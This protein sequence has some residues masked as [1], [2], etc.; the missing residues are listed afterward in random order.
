MC[1]RQRRQQY[2]RNYKKQPSKIPA[3]IWLSCVS[4]ILANVG[5][6]GALGILLL[7][8]TGLF[9]GELITQMKGTAMP[10]MGTLAEFNFLLGMLARMY[11][12]LPIMLLI[13]LVA[14]NA[15]GILVAFF[16]PTRNFKA[17]FIMTFRF[18]DML[19]DL[20][21]LQNDY[22]FFFNKKRF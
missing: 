6:R 3:S 5:I 1:R 12:E 10:A 13:F 14:E 19:R 16:L 9:S 11:H 8:A 22:S 7:Q 4:N 18:I 17:I 21:Q 2:Y 20:V 15:I